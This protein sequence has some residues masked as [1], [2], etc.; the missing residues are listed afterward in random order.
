MVYSKL[1]KKLCLSIQE[2][3]RALLALQ[4]QIDSF[5][6]VILQNCQALDMLI[7]V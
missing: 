5:A 2:T 4:T 7:A 3:T 6:R 1:S